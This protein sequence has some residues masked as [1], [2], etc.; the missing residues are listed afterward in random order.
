MVTT[1]HSSASP[2]VSYGARN[3]PQG[4]PI[5][6]VHERGKLGLWLGRGVKSGLG[7]P[8]RGVAPLTSHR[9]LKEVEGPEQ[10]GVSPHVLSLLPPIDIPIYLITLGENRRP[11]LIPPFSL[12]LIHQQ[13]SCCFCL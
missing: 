2:A 9:T 3:S 8:G 10:A 12:P 5:F 13:H 11:N 6:T 1:H 4:R 7:W